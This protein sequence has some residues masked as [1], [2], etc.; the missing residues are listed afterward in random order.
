MKTN[1]GMPDFVLNRI[2]EIM[3]ENNITDI[4][5]VGLY[6]LS[7][8]ENVDDPRESPTIQLLESQERHLAA[9]L[10]SYDP[11]F[12]KDI[13]TNQYHDFEKFLEDTEGIK[14]GTL[15]LVGADEQVIYENFKLLLENQTAYN[16]MSKASNPY[17]D[18]FACKRIAD[19]L[20][21]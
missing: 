1:D 6:G 5:R 7:Y 3:K 9:P 20:V 16:A 13:V 14:A 11:F 19:V 4:N 18:G 8:K 15:K 2:Y 21:K 10:K 12:E 17:G